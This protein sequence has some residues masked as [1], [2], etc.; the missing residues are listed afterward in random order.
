MLFVYLVVIAVGRLGLII[1][2]ECGTGR[3]SRKDGPPEGTAAGPAARPA[4]PRPLDLATR[5]A[6]PT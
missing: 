6:H 2:C 4:Q 1:P 3:A 5:L